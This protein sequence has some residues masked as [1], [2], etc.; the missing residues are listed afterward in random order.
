MNSVVLFVMWVLVAVIPWQDRGL[1]VHF[2]VP[3]QFT[4]AGSLLLLHE[5]IVEESRKKDRK[6]A[7]GLL[8]EIHSMETCNRLMSNLVDSVQFLLEDCRG[9][10]GCLLQK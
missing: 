2:S 8:R 4:W 7:C 3:R 5:R 9:R 10:R 1:L 6:N